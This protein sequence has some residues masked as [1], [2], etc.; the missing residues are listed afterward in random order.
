MFHWPWGPSI[1]W[2]TGQMLERSSGITGSHVNVERER[3]C[4]CFTLGTY[5]ICVHSTGRNKTLSQ[6]K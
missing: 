5:S 1:S 3:M 4:D 6:V 2:S